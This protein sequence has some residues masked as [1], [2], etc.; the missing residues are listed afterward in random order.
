VVVM[1]NRY[2]KV[3]PGLSEEARPYRVESDVAEVEPGGPD[4]WSALTKFVAALR[5]EYGQR[6]VA[7]VLFGSRARGDASA[8]SDADVAVVLADGDWQAWRERR[9]LAALS[10]DILIETGL[11]I[12]P[13]AFTATEWRAASDQLPLVRRAQ[14]EGRTLSIGE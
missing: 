3:N 8:D 11:D 9:S 4:E 7:V 12:Q 6:L 5:E 13:W 10:Y 2:S 1:T 14:Q